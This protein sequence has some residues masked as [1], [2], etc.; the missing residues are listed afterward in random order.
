MPRVYLLS[1]HEYSDWTLL[2]VYSTREKAEAAKA[3][4]ERPHAVEWKDKPHR[5]IANP[6]QEYVLDVAHDTD[7]WPTPETTNPEEL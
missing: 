4:Y 1:A 5:Y 3:E 6:I 7:I 2:G